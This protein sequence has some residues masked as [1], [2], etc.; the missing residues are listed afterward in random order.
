M[1][2]CGGNYPV[3]S[4]QKVLSLL[5]HVNSHPLISTGIIVIGS[6]P[7]RKLGQR[8]SLLAGEE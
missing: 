1:T 8:Y 2:Q 6:V 4:L 5:L 7:V 3:L